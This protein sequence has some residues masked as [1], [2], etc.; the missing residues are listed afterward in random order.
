M[1]PIYNFIDEIHQTIDDRIPPQLAYGEVIE[2]LPNLKINLLGMIFEKNQ[3]YINSELLHRFKGVVTETNDNHSHKVI[4]NKLK[5]GDM[6]A[7]SIIGDTITVI[8]KVVKAN[9]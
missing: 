9:G 4:Y 8:C 2:P 6:V 1:D 7:C 5:K 3:I